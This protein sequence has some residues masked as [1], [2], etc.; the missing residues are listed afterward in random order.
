MS[1]IAYT[2]L[3]NRRDEAAPETSSTKSN[4]GLKPYIDA[5][6]A[7]VPAEGL[8]LHAIIVS[9][10]TK[11]THAGAENSPSAGAAAAGV[12]FFVARLLGRRVWGGL[13]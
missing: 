6:A 5:L 1:I 12:C 10:T 7:L 13:V 9:A 11:T 8:S 2:Q 3:T 4:P